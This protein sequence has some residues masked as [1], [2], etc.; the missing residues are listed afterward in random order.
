MEKCMRL[1]SLSGIAQLALLLTFVTNQIFVDANH[2]SRTA[3]GADD[4]DFGRG[5]SKDHEAPHNDEYEHVAV[6]PLCFRGEDPALHD[7]A[8][9]HD[10]LRDENIAT[11]NNHRRQLRNTLT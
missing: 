11:E 6:K 4:P 9:K 10:R 7:A 2:R 1:P 5:L 3:P 8:L